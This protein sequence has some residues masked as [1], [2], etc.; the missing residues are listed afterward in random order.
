MKKY[1]IVVP[2]YYNEGELQNTFTALKEKVV[3]KNPEFTGE[4]IF[5]DDGSK[6]NSFSELLGIQKSNPGLV[7]VIKLTRNFGQDSAMLAGYHNSTGDC[8]I[9]ISADLQDPPE[10]I[11]EMLNH[12]FKENYQIVLCHRDG[13][14]ESFIRIITSKFFYFIMRLLCFPNMPKG[15]FDFAL[16]SSKVMKTMFTGNEANFSWQGSILFSGFKI[17]FIPYKRRERLIGKSRWTFGKKIKMLI[18]GILAYSYFPIRVMSVAGIIISFL[19]FIYAGMIIYSRLFG[20]DYP[21]KG[22]APIMVLILVLSG[23]QMLMLGVIGEY[24]WR[25]LDQVRNRPK[26]IIEKVYE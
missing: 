5:I 1:T 15:G 2:V 13:R 9:N 14:D 20:G 3:D 8:I 11:N 21:F 12:H 6:D 4:I 23:F 7:K 25:A 22:W 26:Y 18:D 17:K 10:L 24:L 16:I 19:G